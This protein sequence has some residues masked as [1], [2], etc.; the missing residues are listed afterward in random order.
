MDPLLH[1][2]LTTTHQN[3]ITLMPLLLMD[4]TDFKLSMVRL[5]EIESTRQRKGR[6]ER[7]SAS[8]QKLDDCGWVDRGTHS[9]VALLVFPCDGCDWTW[10]FRFAS[11]APNQAVNL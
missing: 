3:V 8:T 11:T 4:R 6:G 1:V 2:N 10:F 7:G 9:L 5:P